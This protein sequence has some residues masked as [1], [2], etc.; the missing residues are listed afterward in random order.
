MIETKITSVPDLAKGGSVSLAATP[1]QRETI[2]QIQQAGGL[3]GFWVLVSGKLVLVCT[4]PGQEY[5]KIGEVEALL[6]ER[7]RPWP[8]AALIHRMQ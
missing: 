2:R 1:L 4:D 6:K 7:G 3:A 8:I 5:L